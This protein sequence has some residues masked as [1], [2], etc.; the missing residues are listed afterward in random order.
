MWRRGGLSLCGHRSD[1]A[2]GEGGALHAAGLT[3]GGAAS[4]AATWCT[5]ERGKAVAGVCAHVGGRLGTAAHVGGPVLQRTW[6]PRHVEAGHDGCL[7]WSD[8]EVQQIGEPPEHCSTYAAIDN[9]ERR[10]RFSEQT[11]DAIDFE[12]KLNA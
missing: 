4:G 2:S 6:T 1:G 12:A 7:L 10:R 3:T 9:G 5:R 11:D 8:D